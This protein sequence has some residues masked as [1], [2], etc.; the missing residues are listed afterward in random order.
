MQPPACT[1]VPSP[2]CGYMNAIPVMLQWPTQ[3]ACYQCEREM[4]NII[5]QIDKAF[6]NNALTSAAKTFDKS[7]AASAAL[8]SPHLTC[9]APRCRGPTDQSIRASRVSLSTS[10]AQ[11][12][13]FSVAVGIVAFESVVC[14]PSFACRGRG[15]RAHSRRF[16]G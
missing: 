3:F 4:S 10:S 8:F 11:K 2:L 5:L 12:S 9:S 16:E 6:C 1:K 7:K 13:S 15:T 14:L